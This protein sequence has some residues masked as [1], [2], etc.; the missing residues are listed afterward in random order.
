MLTYDYKCPIC[1]TTEEHLVR[2]NTVMEVHCLGCTSGVAVRQLAA[3]RSKL[4][5]SD[6]GFPD[7]YD[8]WAK[9]HENAGHPIAGRPGTGTEIG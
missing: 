4:D 3:P 8:K 1:G 2:D 9:Q 7:A 6:P 5:G